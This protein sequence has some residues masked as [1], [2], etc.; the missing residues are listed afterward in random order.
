MAGGV[1]RF[2]GLELLELVDLMRD[3]PVPD[4]AEGLGR[5]SY[6]TARFEVGEAVPE[7]AFTVALRVLSRACASSSEMSLIVLAPEISP[8]PGTP[9]GTP[10][11]SLVSRLLLMLLNELEVPFTP[12]WIVPGNVLMVALF[13]GIGAEMFL[14]AN[15]ERGDGRDSVLDGTDDKEFTGVSEIVVLILEREILLVV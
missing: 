3:Q 9:T 1:G 13:T 12:P 2:L 14:S 4:C 11:R 8:Q 15:G 7:E 6:S 10:G 5:G